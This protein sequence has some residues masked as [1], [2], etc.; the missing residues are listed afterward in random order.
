MVVVTSEDKPALAAH[1]QPAPAL[2]REL[3]RRGK[4]DLLEVVRTPER[5]ARFT[6]VNQAE[7]RGLGHAVWCARDAVGDE[8]FAVLLPDELFGGSALLERS[9]G[10][11]SA[12]MPP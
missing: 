10:R 7:P 9:C 5:L 1:F 2:E 12:S 3:E 8:P 6:F 4:V 11:T